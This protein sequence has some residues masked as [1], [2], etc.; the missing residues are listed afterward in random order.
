MYIPA[1]LELEDPL[2]VLE[3]MLTPELAFHV[4]IPYIGHVP[5]HEQYAPMLVIKL[6]KIEPVRDGLLWLSMYIPATV[7][8]VRLL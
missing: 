6:V 1:D 3:V 4:I 8:F 5:P 2:S 7:K